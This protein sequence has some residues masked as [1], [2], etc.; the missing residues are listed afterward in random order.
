MLIKL[1]KWSKT[2]GKKY[3]RERIFKCLENIYLGGKFWL[4]LLTTLAKK[5]TVNEKIIQAKEGVNFL[6]FTA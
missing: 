3:K 1:V 6:I 4:L 2:W 5:Y